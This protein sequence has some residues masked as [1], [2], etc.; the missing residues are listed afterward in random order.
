MKKLICLAFV[1][2]AALAQAVSVS[3]VSARQR[4]PWN[5]LVDVT[6]DVDGTAGAAYSVEVRAT[7]ANGAQELTARTLRSEPI[8]KVGANR[9][10]W[11]F[12]ADYPNFRADDMKVS[13]LVT[14]FSDATPVYLIID[15]SGGVSATSYPVRYTTVDPVHTVGANDPCKTTE[16]WLKR[17]KAGGGTVSGTGNYGGFKGHTFNLTED[18]YLGI[19]P[20]TQAQWEK[21]G[22][23]L[24][25]DG[26]HSFF[27]NP[28]YAATR[29]VDNVG[30]YPVY[31]SYYY[32]QDATITADS[33]F[34]RLRDKT[35]LA[36][37]NLPSAW[38]FQWA[39]RAGD[40]TGGQYAGCTPRTRANSLP[41]GITTVANKDSTWSEDYGT[42]Y[43][44]RGAPNAWGFYSMLGNVDEWSCTMKGWESAL[45]EGDILPDDY[46][47]PLPG[48]NRE[49]F[50]FIQGGNWASSISGTWEVELRYDS[51][52]TSY[53]GAYLPYSYNQHGTGLNEG[54]QGFRICL[55]L[56]K[57][58]Q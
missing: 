3:N 24:L 23:G 35:G 37:L 51:Y 43:V 40:L 26:Q 5:N 48:S 42:C 25:T 30:F 32:P 4:W 20:V 6:F 27:T 34:K 10:V 18:Y 33:F 41:A 7:C 45:L 9:L 36:R 57:A 11:D 15:V 55:P 8:A 50:R 31:G 56:P 44:D 13:V 53:Y 39:V 22:S 14:P 28:A 49:S 21:V 2:C 58:A 16:I 19:F 38:Q 54:T 12:G 1:A 47:G 29:P 46:I 52:I 17:V